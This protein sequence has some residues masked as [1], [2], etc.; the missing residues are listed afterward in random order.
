MCSSDAQGRMK[1]KTQMKENRKVVSSLS[2]CLNFIFI[3]IEPGNVQRKTNIQTSV[4]ATVW[5]T[6]NQSDHLIQIHK[7]FCHTSLKSHVFVLNAFSKKMQAV[8]LNIPAIFE[9]FDFL[10]V[11]P[12]V[13]T[14]RLVHEMENQCHLTYHKTTSPK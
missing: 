9:F 3:S 14:T 8:Y 1:Q 12:E 4:H 6:F 5:K 13:M 7:M 2:F 11:P 10:A